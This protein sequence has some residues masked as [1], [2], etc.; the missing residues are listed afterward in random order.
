MP[1]LR[2]GDAVRLSEMPEEDLNATFQVR[3]IRHRIDKATGFVTDVWFRS[4]EAAA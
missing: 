2:L 4:A 3:R 1:A